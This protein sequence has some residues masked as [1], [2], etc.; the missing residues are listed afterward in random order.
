MTVVPSLENMNLDI[1]QETRVAASIEETFAALLDELGPLMLGMEDAPMPMVLEA[2]PGGR[3]YR[4]L[5]NDDGHYWG[6]VKAIRKPNL[7]EIYGPLMMSFPVASNLQY[8]L[9]VEG[10]ETV[11]TLRHTALGLF[12]EGFRDNDKEGWTDITRRVQSRF[13]G[14]N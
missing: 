8:R 13:T 10:N 9:K 7:L 11:I 6:T 14:T 2:R 3:W 12:P 5:G 4:D 1:L